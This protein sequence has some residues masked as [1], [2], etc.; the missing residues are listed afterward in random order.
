MTSSLECAKTHDMQDS[1]LNV[2]KKA[3]RTVR[4]IASVMPQRDKMQKELAEAEAAQERGYYLPDEDD[5]VREIFA[6]YLCARGV[7]LETVESIQPI[8]DRESEEQTGGETEDRHLRTFIV[9]FAAAT[10]LVRS[11][12]F[13]MGM[14]RP[15]S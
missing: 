5:Y 3:A 14:N 1:V 2:I 15:S 12:N 8:L 4:S 11:A 10:M 7:L 9:G 6:R 13:M